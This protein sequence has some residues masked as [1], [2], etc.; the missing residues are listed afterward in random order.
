MHN[1]FSDKSMHL[2]TNSMLLLSRDSSITCATR[3]ASS[4]SS[5]SLLS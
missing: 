3:I 4:Y 5:R 1:R 2:V